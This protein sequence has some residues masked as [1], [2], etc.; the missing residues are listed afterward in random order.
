METKHNYLQAGDWDDDGEHECA[1]R[2]NYGWAV[3]LRRDLSGVCIYLQYG[4][5][6]AFDFG[7]RRAPRCGHTWAPPTRPYK[8]PESFARIYPYI[9]LESV[10]FKA[11]LRLAPLGLDPHTF[12]QLEP[13]MQAKDGSAKFRAAAEHP[14]AHPDSDPMAAFWVPTYGRI[15]GAH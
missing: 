4:F 14:V 8:T 3:C 13:L 12:K 1:D 11:S 7:P 10:R 5:H 9:L 15:G 2:H 6:S